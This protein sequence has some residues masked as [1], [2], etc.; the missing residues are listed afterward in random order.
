MVEV[1]IQERILTLIVRAVVG[2]AQWTYR[3][4]EKQFLESL[5]RGA[6]QAVVGAGSITYR[7]VEQKGLEGILRRIVRAALAIGRGLQRLHTGRLQRNLVWV[8]VSLLLAVLALV[9]CS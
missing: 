8:A 3:V 1:G 5:Q 4:M 9:F 2:A 7:I 6:V